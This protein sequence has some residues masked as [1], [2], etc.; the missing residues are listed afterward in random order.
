MN[1]TLEVPYRLQGDLPLVL[2]PRD[3][4]PDSANLDGLCEWL[5]ANPEWVQEKLT[6]HGALRFNG[7]GV[8]TPEAFEKLARAIDDELGNDYL[9]TSPRDGLTDYVFSASE[10]PG[11]Y[12]IP[13]HCE[14]SFC[15]HPPRRVFF[16][17]FEEPAKGSG[18]TPLCDFRK[19]WEE[20]D[21]DLR[22][23]FVDGGLRIVRNYT[24]RGGERE[25]DPTMLKPWDEMFLTTD[26]EEVERQCSTEGFE[27]TWL[28]KDGLRLVS[29]QPIYRAHPVSGERVWH[30]HLTTVHLTTAEAELRR[31]AELRPSDRHRGVHGIAKKLEADLRAQP[32]DERSMHCTYLD[33]SELPDADIEAV[34]DAVWKHTVVQPWRRG[35]VV[36]LDNDAVS[37]GR[38]PYEGPRQVAVA[39]A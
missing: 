34:R 5:R 22:Q 12:P 30:N 16:C 2:S 27:V 3:E 20:L 25:D 35:D 6:R 4:Q 37:H 28:P 13:Q 11:F 14:M 17:C 38:L 24:G 23:R 9:G 8:T 15:A 21:P 29:S 1:S 19:V 36:A 18:E 32:S 10:L 26:R 33:G 39:W 7:F 31:I